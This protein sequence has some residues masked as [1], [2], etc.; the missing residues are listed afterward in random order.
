MIRVICFVFCCCAFNLGAEGT[1]DGKYPSLY[2]YEKSECGG[3]IEEPT[4]S[5]KRLQDKSTVLTFPVALYGGKS[6]VNS[7]LNASF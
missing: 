3:L 7:S 4:L 2:E 5:I 1:I 6:L